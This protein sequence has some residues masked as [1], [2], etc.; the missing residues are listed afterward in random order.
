MVDPQ[1]GS[2]SPPQG[3]TGKRRNVVLSGWSGH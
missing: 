3:L 2:A 1:L